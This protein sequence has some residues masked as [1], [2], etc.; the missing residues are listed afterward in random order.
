MGYPCKVRDGK[1]VEPCT[2]LES[3]MFGSPFGRGNGLFLYEMSD[4]KV[5]KP[6][7]SFVVLRTGKNVERGVAL[8]CCPFCKAEIDA[9]FNEVDQLAEAAG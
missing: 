6:T 3:A 2:S 4:L 8:N 5:G 9:P 7:R 1:F